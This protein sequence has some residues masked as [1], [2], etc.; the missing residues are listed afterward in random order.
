ML[1][2][3]SLLPPYLTILPK[4]VEDGKDEV[5]LRGCIFPFLILPKDGEDEEGGEDE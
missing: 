2:D 4:N 1:P 3:P 5:R